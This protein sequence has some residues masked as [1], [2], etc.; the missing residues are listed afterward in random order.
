MFTI[1]T[2]S[3]FSIP[4]IFDT[5]SKQMD[6]LK[7]SGFMQNS[8]LRMKMEQATELSFIKQAHR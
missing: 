4:G 8:L 6:V 3:A 7:K 5:V 1:V 2:D